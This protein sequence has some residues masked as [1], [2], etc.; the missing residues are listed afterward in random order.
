MALHLWRD[1]ALILLIL[2]LI[3]LVLPFFFLFYFTLKGLLSLNRWARGFLPKVGHGVSH[4][5]AVTNRAASG[6]AAPVI[7]V[8]SYAAFGKGLVRGTLAVVKGK[9]G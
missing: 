2:E 5:Q 6:V 3:V 8:Y 7:A 1:L 9:S 4:I